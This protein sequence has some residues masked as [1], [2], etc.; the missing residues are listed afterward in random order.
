MT[1]P[2]VPPAESRAQRR[3]RLLDATRRAEQSI[4]ESLIEHSESEQDIRR[5]RANEEIERFLP[6][7]T[8]D[9]QNPSGMYTP[10][11]KY[12]AHNKLRRNSSDI[13]ADW[14]FSP[15]R[16]NL[17]ARGTLPQKLNRGL[18][19]KKRTTELHRKLVVTIR[20]LQELVSGQKV[21]RPMNLSIGQA[22]VQTNRHPPRRV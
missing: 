1:N 17:T 10:D 9:E 12:F 4:N 16:R 22:T 14:A 7:V 5:R 8:E 13:E 21:C 15:M 3:V 18:T 20:T 6:G 19:K 2:I 11:P